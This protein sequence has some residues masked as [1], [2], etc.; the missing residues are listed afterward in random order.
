MVKQYTGEKVDVY[1]DPKRCVHATE[2]VRGLS[3]VFDV[4]E[5]PWVQPDNASEWD[6]VKV[7]ERCPSGALTYERASGQPETH[8]ETSVTMGDD[9]EIYMYGDFKL[10]HNGEVM[11]LNRAIL[12]GDA[13]RTDNPPFYS[14]SFSEQGD[15]ARYYQAIQDEPNEN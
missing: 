11:Q 9:G 4:D 10:V 13:S 8:R 15:K 3:N 5:R 14:K 2:C 6:V 12:T 7:I 1:F